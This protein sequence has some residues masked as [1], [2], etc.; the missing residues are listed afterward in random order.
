MSDDKLTQTH[1]MQF[2]FDKE[3]KEVLREVFQIANMNNL[4]DEDR[5]KVACD[6]IAHA[7]RKARNVRVNVTVTL[8][9]LDV[10]G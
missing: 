3:A 1:A 8:T 6:V 9:P 2:D 10:A 5:A 7:L 4:S